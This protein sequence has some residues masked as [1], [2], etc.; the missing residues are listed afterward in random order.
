MAGLE[1]K[2][3]LSVDDS[4]TIRAFLRK[5]LT[6]RGAEVEEVATGEEAVARCTVGDPYDLVLLDLMLPDLNG[7]EVLRRIR[8]GNDRSAVV[9]LTGTGGVKEAIAAISEGADGYVEK[10]ELS[11]GGDYAE[12]FY[13]L[14]QALDHRAGLI[15]QKELEQVKADF[16]SMVV[17]DLR[18]PAGSIFTAIQMLLDGEFGPLSPEQREILS[19]AKEAVEKQLTLIND[20]LDYSKIEAG[21]L[22][23]ALGEA[24]L[25]EVVRGSA[26]LARLQAEAKGQSLVLEL[27]EEPVTARVD[28]ER[29][30]QVLDNL[31][32]NAVKYTPEGGRI[33]VHLHVEG[34]HAVFR[35][36]DTGPGI[37]PEHLPAL[38]T[39]YHRVPGKA[40]RAVQG[41]GLGLLIVKEI[42]EAHGGRV[43]AESEGVPGKGA[44]FTFVI[45]LAGPGGEQGHRR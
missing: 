30:K 21:Y 39:K 28:A 41:T 27:P 43:W 11:I 29:L 10:Q 24:D 37:P 40:T 45:P 17:H 25:R 12:F 33:A 4:P 44:T 38:F 22:K 42:V 9:I 6:M 32:S 34:E 35:V 7:L 36:S 26:E 3:V 23:L 16:Y 2:R 18:G 15:A 5:L 14:E 1:G 19:L 13:A 20:Y 8:A 31:L